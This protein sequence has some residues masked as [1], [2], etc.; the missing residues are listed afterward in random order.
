MDKFRSAMLAAVLGIAFA[1]G[2]AAQMTAPRD[3]ARPPAEGAS[4]TDPSPRDAQDRRDPE[5]DQSNSD[6]AIERDKCGDLSDDA[7]ERCILDA[8]MQRDR[9]PLPSAVK[10]PSQMR[11][12]SK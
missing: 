8:R 10:S 1:S 3:S 11:G 2:A 5:K 4:G 12:P 6:L 7:K 9:I